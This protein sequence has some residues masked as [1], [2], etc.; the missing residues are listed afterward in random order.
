MINK[1]IYIY[2]MILIRIQ[3][4]TVKL[5]LIYF[6]FRQECDECIELK[7]KNVYFYNFL[8]CLSSPF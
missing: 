4:D 5:I 8:F 2:F 7:K 6:T 3:I 1:K